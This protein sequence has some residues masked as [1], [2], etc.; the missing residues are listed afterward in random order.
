MVGFADSNKNFA[1]PSDVTWSYERIWSSMTG[2][3]FVMVFWSR[4]GGGGNYVSVTYQV[5]VGLLS[6]SWIMRTEVCLI[7]VIL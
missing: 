6:T 1:R 4:G 3:F 7:H 2:S 5:I